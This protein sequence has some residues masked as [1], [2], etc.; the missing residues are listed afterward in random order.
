MHYNYN[1][2]NQINMNLIIKIML[3]NRNNLTINIIK[4]KNRILNKLIIMT[5]IMLFNKKNRKKRKVLLINLTK[6][7]R[8]FLIFLNLKIMNR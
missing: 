8:N 4:N 1:K 2:K 3:I 6:L 7:K 5:K